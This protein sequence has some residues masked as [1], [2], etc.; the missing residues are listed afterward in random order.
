MVVPWPARLSTASVAS[1]AS[2]RSR[3]PARPEP[4]VMRGAA[5]PVVCDRD[6]ESPLL[7]L[8]QT[9]ASARRRVLDDVRERLRDDEIRGELDRIRQSLR[10]PFRARSPATAP[11]VP[12]PR[13]QPG[14]LRPARA[15]GGFLA[16]AR[17]A[18]RSPA[19][20]RPGRARERLRWPASA[21]D[22]SRPSASDNVTSLCCAPSCRL[23]SMRPRSASAAATIRPRDARTS[24][25]C[26][27]TSAARRSFSSTSPAVARTDSTSAGSSSS[28]GS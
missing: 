28:A 20:P 16:R 22:A 23:R 24:A 12:G 19:R 9:D 3:R 27:R 10:A 5:A 1:S 17:E 2:R 6:A 26:E 18:R 15:S 11:V 4:A 25:S 21:R 14:D 7:L 13:P 8:E